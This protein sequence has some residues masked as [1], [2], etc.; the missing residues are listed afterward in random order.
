MVRERDGLRALEMCVSRQNGIGVLRGFLINCR[1]QPVQ[2]RADF[3]RLLPQVEAQVGSHLIVAGTGGVQPLSDLAD[4]ADQL[5]LD[6]RVD[7]LRAHVDGECAGF[8]VRENPRKSLYDFVA[9]VR[10][11]DAL[12]REH[13][14]VRHGACNILFYHLGIE[15]DRGVD[16]VCRGIERAGRSSRP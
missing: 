12:R 9:V 2:K 4:A 13:R 5:G 1:N 3:C 8:D 15:G 16:V 11:D 10:G 14:R 6:K 7:V